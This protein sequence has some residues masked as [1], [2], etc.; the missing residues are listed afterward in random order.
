MEGS[1]CRVAVRGKVLEGDGKTGTDVL[2]EVLVVI[3]VNRNPYAVYWKGAGEL[4]VVRGCN[5]ARWG[6][7]KEPCP[8]FYVVYPLDWVEEN[9]PHV[10]PTLTP[11]Q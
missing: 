5:R 8:A 1:P 9:P 10:S 4:L 2:R 11:Y 6:I 7:L 3:L